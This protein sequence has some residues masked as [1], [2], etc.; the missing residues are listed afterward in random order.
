MDV[1]R[2]MEFILQ[3]QAQTQE[4]LR[5]T[6]ETLRE[7]QETLRETQDTLREMAVAGK[8]TDQRLDRLER[9]VKTLSRAG[10]RA[11]NRL[12]RSAEEHEKWLKDVDQKIAEITDKLNGLIDVVD[13]WP[14]DRA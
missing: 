10:A 9:F 6:Q 13:R 1:E 14:R 5:E 2:T 8:R 7:T 11:R 4:T 12:S 3:T